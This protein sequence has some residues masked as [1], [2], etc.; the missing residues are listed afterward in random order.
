[1]NKV[2]K[3][4]NYFRSIFTQTTPIICRTSNN[5][6][7]HLVYL[8][9]METTVSVTNIRWNIKHEENHFWAVLVSVINNEAAILLNCAKTT[10]TTIILHVACNK[11]TVKVFPKVQGQK[12]QNKKN[13][14]WTKMLR[15]AA[16]GTLCLMQKTWQLHMC[17]FK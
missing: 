17:N 1:M 8:V 3:L 13:I 6:P 7:L 4:F 9:T 14:K 15:T 12:K 16:V 2:F 10:T 11:F 5:L